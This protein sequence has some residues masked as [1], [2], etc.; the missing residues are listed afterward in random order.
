MLL[1]TL[2]D[3]GQFTDVSILKF[4]NCDK[5]IFTVLLYQTVSQLLH[6]DKKENRDHP[7]DDRLPVH[8]SGYG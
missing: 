7:R 1:L 6:I 3:L 8:T 5:I 2:C 4:Q